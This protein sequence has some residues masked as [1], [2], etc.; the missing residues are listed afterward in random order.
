MKL[1]FFVVVLILLFLIFNS[2]KISE[3]FSAGGGSHGGG[4]HGGGSHRGGSHGGGGHGYGGHGGH[5]PRYYN[6]RNYWTGSGGGGY[7]DLLYSGPYY[8]WYDPLY[9]VSYP[10]LIN[11]SYVSPESETIKSEN[12]IKIES[13]SI[14]NF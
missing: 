13:E 5:Y 7:G 9:V 8:W 2:N 14:F 1:I 12:L 4:S 10:V 6:G 11:D 3:K